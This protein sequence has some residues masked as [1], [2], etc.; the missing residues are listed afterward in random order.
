L[1][2]I[3]SAKFEQDLV[4]LDAARPHG[5]ERAIAL[6]HMDGE[7]IRAYA[8]AYPDIPNL[9]DILLLAKHSISIEL[10][11]REEA[12]IAAARQQAAAQGQNNWQ[13]LRGRARRAANA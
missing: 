7:I 13:I 8:N 11:Q 4:D 10:R 2:N 3:L 6:H 9:G 5:G 12:A 1:R